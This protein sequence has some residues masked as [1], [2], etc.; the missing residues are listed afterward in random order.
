[1]FEEH[2]PETVRLPRLPVREGELVALKRESGNQLWRVKRIRNDI[3]ICESK[4]ESFPPTREVGKEFPIADLVVVRNFG[5]PIYP[6]L[7]AVD[8][9]QRGGP[10]NRWH[11]HINA[12]NY[13][14]LQLL[15]YCYEG[16][17][18][19]IYIDLPYNTGARDWKY[20]N[21]YVDKND[22]FRHS[23]WLSM[24]KKRL[25]LVK[26]LLKPDGVFIVTIDEHEVHHLGNLLEEE[27][28]EYSRQ[29]VTIVI[30]QKGVAQGRLSRVEEHAFF[31]FAPGAVI[32]AITERLGEFVWLRR[33]FFELKPLAKTP[34]RTKPSASSWT[35]R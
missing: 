30:N 35:N 14:A 9:V 10:D 24:M 6:A 27:L 19:V 4:V 23:K 34:T 33:T 29:M 20:N 18:D 13:Q 15:L 31:C 17:A 2:L 12:D 3:A 22:T 5:E 28:R 1:V 25:R 7:V 16:K 21:D 26:Q 32:P 11:V 8:R